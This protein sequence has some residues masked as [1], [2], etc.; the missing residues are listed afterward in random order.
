[1]MKV[2][3]KGAAG[4]ADE[5]GPKKRSSPTADGDDAVTKKPKKQ[6][7]AKPAQD[8]AEEDG[9]EEEEE[10]EEVE[11][12]EEAGR[13]PEKACLTARAS[14]SRPSGLREADT[15]L[16]SCHEIFRESKDRIIALMERRTKHE[17]ENVAFFAKRRE[18]DE[19]IQSIFQRRATEDAKMR[20]EY[21]KR[22]KEFEKE[23][24]QHIFN[25]NAVERA[26]S[27]CHSVVKNII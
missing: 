15:A 20:T 18:E 14:G 2:P 1:M 3:T 26:V 8:A 7:L 25:T 13:E 23:V 24:A 17:V 21:E 10:E 5:A 4:E 22:D 12:E 19:M 27:T 11:E 9:D 16:K 6:K